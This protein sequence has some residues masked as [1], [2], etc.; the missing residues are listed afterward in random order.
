M[1]LQ[2]DAKQRPKGITDQ[3]ARS[4]QY[5]EERPGFIHRVNL[6]FHQYKHWQTMASK[7][8]IIVSKRPG[9]LFKLRK[10]KPSLVKSGRLSLRKLVKRYFDGTRRT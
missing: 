6:V 4:G 5:E 7:R 10:C 3:I 8:D 9:V 2:E 1:E